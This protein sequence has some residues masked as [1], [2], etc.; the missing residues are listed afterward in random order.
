MSP[1]SGSGA[2][3]ALRDAAGPGEALTTAAGGDP[4]AALRDYE[5]HMFDYG[6]AAVREGAANDCWARSLCRCGNFSV[7]RDR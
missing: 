5:Q 6:F 4:D 7:R 1:A 3:T 2:C